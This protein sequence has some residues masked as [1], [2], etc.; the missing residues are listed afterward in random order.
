MTNFDQ[1]SYYIFGLNETDP[2]TE[3]K[4]IKYVT[5]QK[6]LQKGGSD[7]DILE[8]NLDGLAKFVIE[9]HEDIF[10]RG[11]V[12]LAMYF[13][14]NPLFEIKIDSS[15]ERRAFR[16]SSEEQEKF[17][18]AIRTYDLQRRLEHTKTL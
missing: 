9:H 13:S 15:G 8:D 3:I 2:K 7:F 14:F 11:L 17:L 1:Q 10:R 12:P 16:L 6:A 5:C 4:K 18:D